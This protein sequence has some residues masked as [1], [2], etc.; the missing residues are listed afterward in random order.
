MS[1]YLS[2]SIC[3]SNHMYPSKIANHIPNGY[4]QTDTNEEVS[5]R[6]KKQK[7][8]NTLTIFKIL[9]LCNRFFPRITTKIL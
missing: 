6:K 5:E 7:N 2:F 8:V 1:N 4:N 3:L 9:Q